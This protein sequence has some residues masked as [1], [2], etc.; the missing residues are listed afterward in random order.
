MSIS[1]VNVVIGYLTTIEDGFQEETDMNL[2]KGSPT[3]YDELLDLLAETSLAQ[4]ILDFKASP[5]T[6]ARID[7]LLE[8]NRNGELSLE[9]SSELDEFERLEHLVRMLKARVRQ[10]L[11][12]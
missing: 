2:P 5:E 8:K 1:K 12:E 4:R 10:N 6:Q 7:R 3:A 9:E 11:L